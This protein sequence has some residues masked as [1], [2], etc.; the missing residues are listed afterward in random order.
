MGT[1]Q[2]KWVNTLSNARDL[3]NLNMLV[4]IGE[5]KRIIR[6]ISTIE[7]KRRGALFLISDFPQPLFNHMPSTTYKSD[8]E[9]CRMGHELA[10]ILCI[11]LARKSYFGFVTRMS[12]IQQTRIMQSNMQKLIKNYDL[13]TCSSSP[14]QHNKSMGGW[15]ICNDFYLL[16]TPSY[17][18]QRSAFCK[19]F[20]W[21]C[22]QLILERLWCAS[23]V[24]G[25]G[26]YGWKIL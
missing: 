15:D 19:C 11:C 10:S 12:N 26:H 24:G 6:E 3:E 13:Y 20:T 4:V 14:S 1:K 21:S 23:S 22:L 25:P 5:R 7:S 9:L 16:R 2:N 17:N 18:R 8:R